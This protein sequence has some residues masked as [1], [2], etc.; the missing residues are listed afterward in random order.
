MPNLRNSIYEPEST[1]LRIND[2]TLNQ[3]ESNNG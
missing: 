3:T 2:L 1:D